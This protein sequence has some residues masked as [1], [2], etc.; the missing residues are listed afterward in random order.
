METGLTGFDEIAIEGLGQG[1][2]KNAIR[3]ALGAPSPDRLLKVAQALRLG[4]DEQQIYEAC[5]IDPWFI[6]QIQDI[7]DTEE[8]V[9]PARPAARRRAV[10]RA[11]GD[12]LLRCAAGEA[13]R[14]RGERGGGAAPGARRA[15]GL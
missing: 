4:F 12:G 7:I 8:R 2:D 10:P 5:A 14:A 15:P 9:A 3:A 6:R 1:D 13:R 11:E